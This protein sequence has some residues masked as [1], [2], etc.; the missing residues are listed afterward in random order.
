MGTGWA[1]AVTVVG[2]VV[3]AGLLGLLARHLG[4]WTWAVTWVKAATEEKM[5][6]CRSQRTTS[7][8]SYMFDN[9]LDW[10]GLWP[11]TGSYKRFTNLDDLTS[12]PTVD[13]PAVRPVEEPDLP[14]QPL[15]PAPAPPP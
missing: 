15:R 5:H 13:D 12:V 2:S 4:L 10:I 6:L 7:T 3:I 1:V 9:D 8:R 11:R 14:P